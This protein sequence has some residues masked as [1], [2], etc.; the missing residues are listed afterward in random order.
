MSVTMKAWLVLALPLD[1]LGNGRNEV[2]LFR[3]V[4]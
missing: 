4:R 2:E 1:T 3:P